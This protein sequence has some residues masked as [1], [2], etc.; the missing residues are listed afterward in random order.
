MFQL[1]AL[2]MLSTWCIV[3]TC[4]W[5]WECNILTL[6]LCEI[7]GC[8]YKFPGESFFL[9]RSLTELD[10]HS[11]FLF[12]LTDSLY[13]VPSLSVWFFD[14]TCFICKT[15]IY[16]PA[17]FRL[18][19]SSCGVPQQSWKPNLRVRP[20]ED[21]YKVLMAALFRI[22]PRRKPSQ[23]LSTMEFINH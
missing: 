12:V 17:L 14:G 5:P 7:R 4:S 11:L 22:V 1:R 23:C 15:G 2:H 21:M 3:S 9:P 8:D 19:I 16:I 6:E 20:P 10:R 18:V 13:S